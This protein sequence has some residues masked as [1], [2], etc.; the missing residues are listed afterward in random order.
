MC[1]IHDKVDIIF[2]LARFSLISLLHSVSSV[3][4]DPRYWNV[5]TCSN[6]FPFRMILDILPF[7]V[8]VLVSFIL[9]CSFFSLP[10]EFRRLAISCVSLSAL[11]A[12]SKIIIVDISQMCYS[13]SS[14]MYA[15][16]PFPASQHLSHHHFRHY[17]K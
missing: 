11:P 16:L 17:V 1:F 6:L 14:Y 2:S 9:T 15:H 3:I 5:S 8:I 10:I 12:K 4:S 13:S 7:S